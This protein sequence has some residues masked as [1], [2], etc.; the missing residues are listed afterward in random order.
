MNTLQSQL[1]ICKEDKRFAENNA[2]PEGVFSV[3]L[4]GKEYT[5]RKD[6]AAVL[7]K[8][9]LSCMV[10]GERQNVGFYR[11]FAVSVSRETYGN[12]SFP[13][14][15][16]RADGLTY[17]AELTLES[18]IGNIIRMEN[19]VKNAIDKRMSDTEEA[20]DKLK[21]DLQEAERTKDLPFELADELKQKSERLEQLNQELNLNKAEDSLIDDEPEKNIAEEKTKPDKN[22]HAV[23]R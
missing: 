18:D 9:I 17:S 4:H 22:I 2:L 21:A 11:G 3:Q 1:E 15:N 23:R 20:I 5:E 14:V 10:S 8:N 16:L 19:V 13:C 7:Q 6:A 12:G